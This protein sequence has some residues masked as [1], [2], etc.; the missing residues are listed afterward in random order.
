LMY[1]KGHDS[2]FERE[3]SSIHCCDDFI[4][5]SDDYYT[6][7]YFITKSTQQGAFCYPFG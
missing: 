1:Y 5:Q 2:F 3:V 7:R 4:Y 6:Y